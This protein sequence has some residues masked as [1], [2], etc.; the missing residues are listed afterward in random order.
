MRPEKPD[1]G[2]AP[3]LRFSPRAYGWT[4]YWVA[5]ADLVKRGFRPATQRL[6]PP[7]ANPTATMTDADQKRIADEC[8]R[9]QNEML[10]WANGSYLEP[11]KAFDGTLA[12]LVAAYK[13]DPDSPYH[14]LRFDSRRTY[15][16]HMKLIE[17]NVGQR[18]LAEVK[19]RDIK[20]WFEK[21][22]EPKN[23]DAPRRVPRAHAAVTMLRMLFAF[24]IVYEYGEDHC[25]RLKAVMSEMDFPGGRTRT[26][27]LTMEHVNAIRKAAHEAGRP[28]VALAAAIGYETAMRPKDGIGEWVPASEPG[29]SDVIHNGKKWLYGI[30]WRSVSDD[31]KLTHRL[32]KSLKGKRAITEREAG[33]VKTYNLNLYP[34]IVEELRILAGF[35]ST[36][37][38]IRRDMFPPAG[39]IVVN[40][41]TGRPW[42]YSSY[43]ETWRKIATSV[44]VPKELQIRDARAAAITE[45]IEASGGD[46]EANRIAAGHSQ[47]ATTRRY[48]RGDER[49]TA[50]IAVLRSKNRPQTA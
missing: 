4:L 41:R 42:V 45:G 50:K 7:S 46:L 17:T 3:G 19:G 5:R 24:G 9:L 6:W 43:V 27:E 40:E 29:M 30:D 13:A 49:Q 20:R 38:V 15:A 21:W 26:A 31:L 1:V 28:S 48:S 34:M 2:R 36:N 10:A 14:D 25:A 23:R 37:G 44:G 8:G 22:S 35:R 32:S 12:S 39:P 47:S 16:Q 33:K 11:Q 18:R